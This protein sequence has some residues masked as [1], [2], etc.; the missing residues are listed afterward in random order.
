MPSRA[1]S[2]LR[3]W[4]ALPAAVLIPTATACAGPDPT[5]DAGAANPAGTDLLLP[6]TAPVTL[7]LGPT[8]GPPPPSTGAIA[9]LAVAD[10]VD[11]AI[12]PDRIL[13]DGV[14]L[15]RPGPDGPV[16]ETGGGSWPDNGD[17]TAANPGQERCIGSGDMVRV[18][19]V[20]R[21]GAI[22]GGG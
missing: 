22:T 2:R 18:F 7:T 14:D 5:A 11:L 8:S 21:E 9:A 13:L 12:T 20:Q 10:S 15:G 4:A 17:L 3:R 6:I 16:L 19:S 1:R